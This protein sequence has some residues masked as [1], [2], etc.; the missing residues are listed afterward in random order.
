MSFRMSN[1]TWRYPRTPKNL[2]RTSQ[3]SPRISKDTQGPFRF[4]PKVLRDP[5]NL[6]ILLAFGNNDV[7]M[8][9]QLTFVEWV[10]YDDALELSFLK[11]CKPVWWV[12]N[13]AF[14]DHGENHGGVVKSQ[15]PGLQPISD[16]WPL[17][18]WHWLPGGQVWRGGQ[19][20]AQWFSFC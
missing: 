10:F 14:G 12:W 2:P 16:F 8:N 19:I 9:R 17:L 3:G 5:D 1:E 13:D 18:N 6:K 4:P 7:N 11:R 15:V 20:S